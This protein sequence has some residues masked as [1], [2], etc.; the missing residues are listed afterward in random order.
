MN[1]KT[2]EIVKPE[3]AITL[4]IYKSNVENHLNQ[5][6]YILDALI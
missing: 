5:H 4:N 3:V 2:T 1:P 6:G